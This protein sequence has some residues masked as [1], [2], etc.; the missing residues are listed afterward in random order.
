MFIII[1][2]VVTCGQFHSLPT[3]VMGRLHGYRGMFDRSRLNALWLPR[4]IMSDVPYFFSC[5]IK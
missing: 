1:H 2:T 4:E 5:K 3:C